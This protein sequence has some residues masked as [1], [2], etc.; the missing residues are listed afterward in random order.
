M[1]LK[2]GVMIQSKKQRDAKFIIYQSL[3]I[4]VIVLLGIKGHT[5]VSIPDKNS[6]PIGQNQIIITKGRHDSL[7]AIEKSIHEKIIVDTIRSYVALKDTTKNKVVQID[8]TKEKI[9]PKN[10]GIPVPV[11]G[12]ES[13]DKIAN[14]QATNAE[15]KRKLEECLKQ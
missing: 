1:C 12:G 13:N 7:L 4:L 8:S 2:T 14:L 10:Y 11:K 3:Y 5:L 15:L 9:V 6:K